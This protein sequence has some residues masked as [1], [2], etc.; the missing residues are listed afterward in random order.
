MY[1]V[2]F[3]KSKNFNQIYVGSTNDL[4][5]RLEE[6]NKGKS[7]STKRYLPWKLIYYEA[8][9]EENF[10]RM[11]E[12]KLKNHG[13]SLRELKKRIGLTNIQ[14]GAGYTLIEIL[15][16]L[17][18]IGLLF[19]FGYVSFR[20]FSRREALTGSIKAIQ[21]D[22]RLTQSLASS[23]QKPDDQSCISPNTLNGYLFTVLSSS[24]YEIR[25]SCS[26]GNVSIANKT[27]TLGT[28]TNIALP[29]PVPN[30]ILFK[31]LDNGTNI[32]DGQNATIKLIQAGTNSQSMITISSGGQ[33]Q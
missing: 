25:A 2:Y 32:P 28:G 12:K 14:S 3:L 18:I 6:H 5:R 26:G 22:L 33:I 20:D 29:Y 27:V 16:G 7:P 30:P 9:E 31:T 10:A 11:R 24:K 17:T 15:V 21:G 4:K 19:S 8:F 23:G 1:Y 13:N